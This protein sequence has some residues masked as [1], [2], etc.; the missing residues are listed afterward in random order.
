MPS[1]K[2]GSTA[3]ANISSYSIEETA[4]PE[5]TSGEEAFASVVNTTQQID[6]VE[7]GTPKTEYV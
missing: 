1:A 4:P 3:S 2:F 6:A 7:T 5:L